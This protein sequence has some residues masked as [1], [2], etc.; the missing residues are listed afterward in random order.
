[1]VLLTVY[2]GHPID[3]VAFDSHY[4]QTHSQLALKIPGLKGYFSTQ[5]ESLSP[6][7]KAPHYLVAELFF[8][9]KEA[10]QSALQSPEGQAT[11]ADAH[12]LATGGLTMFLAEV[13][14]YR[15]TSIG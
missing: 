6:D 2:Y 12:Q 5:P 1:M 14:V 11:A 3:P 9:S 8:E 10:F 7:V 15:R 4:H 13:D